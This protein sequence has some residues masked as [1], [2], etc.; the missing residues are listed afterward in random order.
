MRAS[1]RSGALRRER[2]NSSAP[3][4]QVR[5]NFGRSSHL[6]GPG[7]NLTTGGS[8]NVTIFRAARCT[9]SIQS[10]LDH[11]VNPD[12]IAR[13]DIHML[14][15]SA[16]LAH[17]VCLQCAT[18]DAAFAR[19]QRWRAQS[20]VKTEDGANTKSIQLTCVDPAW[21]ASLGG[22]SVPTNILVNITKNGCVNMFMSVADSFRLGVEDGYRPV[23]QAIVDIVHAAS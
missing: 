9:R 22:I 20:V 2:A 23:Y 14:V 5:N 3:Q 13:V 4:T 19:D 7:C 21:I 17:P 11:A 10:T 8:L 18:V 16:R 12:S 15:A 1:V 6:Y